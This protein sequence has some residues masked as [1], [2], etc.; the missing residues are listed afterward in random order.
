MNTSTSRGFA[1]RPVMALA[2]AVTLSLGLATPVHNA[3]AIFSDVPH[4][5]VQGV[6]F[7][8]QAGR[9]GKTIQQYKQA[10]D[11]YMA[12]LKSLQNM[13]IS[14]GLKPGQP[15]KKIPEDHNVEQRCGSGGSFSL[16]SLVKKVF[17]I[18]PNGDIQKQQREI[19]ASIQMMQNTKFNLTVDFLNEHAEQS[20]QEFNDFSARASQ[21]VNP[22]DS[23][24]VA[25]D[26]ANMEAAQRTRMEN[27]QNKIRAYD[28]YIEIMRENQRLL[29]QSALKPRSKKLI[30]TLVGTA[31]LQVALPLNGVDKPND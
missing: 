16:A 2:A 22:G 30:G 18:D 10:Y 24:T 7:I 25:Q 1:R 14:L 12:Q 4:I 21:V 3:H 19:C 29:A 26:A 13:F 23:D 28:S 11:N 27:F 31:S 9:W 5:I 17:T 8:Q 20:T 6:E 15:L